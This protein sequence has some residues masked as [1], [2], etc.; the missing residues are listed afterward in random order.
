MRILWA[1]LTCRESA[2][3][4]FP[5]R[6]GCR[7]DSIALSPALQA[8]KIHHPDRET[9]SRRFA[10]G[11]WFPPL[12]CLSNHSSPLP[13]RQLC[14]SYRNCRVHT[15]RRFP[16]IRLGQPSLA[17]QPFRHVSAHQASSIRRCFLPP[18]TCS[19]SRDDEGECLSFGTGIR[20]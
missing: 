18:A 19:A 15:A 14:Y 20:V 12:P 16:V 13:P 17:N 8:A 9:R 4:F 1:R 5:F 6:P 11:P 7:E 3:G 10:C 2:F